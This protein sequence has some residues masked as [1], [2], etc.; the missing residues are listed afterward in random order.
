MTVPGT[1][2]VNHIILETNNVILEYDHST[3]GL[4]SPKES[5]FFKSPKLLVY[6]RPEALDIK[7]YASRYMH[8][9]RNRSLEIVLS[10]GWNQLESGELH[11]RAA[12]AGLRVQTSEA[13]VVKGSL[14]L[15]RKSEAGVVRFGTMD[16][17]SSASIVMPFNLE[18][19]VNDISLK[20]EISYTTDKGSFFFATT[21]SV[22]IMLPL[23]VNV[24]DV[25]KHKALFSKFTISSATSSPLRLLGS[26]LEGSEVF[27]A[28]SGL[29][30]SRPLVVFP[31]Q[32]ASMLYKITKSPSST[33]TRPASR[34]GP[35]S[36]LSLVLNYICLEEEIE[37]AVTLSLDQALANGPLAQY[38]R[39]IIP[40][41]LTQV[42]IRLSP[43]DLER[44]AVLSEFSTSILSSVKWRDQFAGLGRSVEQNQE[45]VILIE[46]CIKLWIQHAPNISL[47]PISLTDDTL[48][49]S[50]SIII[51]VDVP[52][53]SVVY[54]ADLKLLEPSSVPLD[55]VLAA[56]NQPLSAS[57]TIKYTRIW[58]TA[59][60][61]GPDTS[62]GDE[63]LEFFY[64]VSGATDTWLI[65][66]KRKGHFRIPRK[67]SSQDSNRKFTFPVVLIP[68]REGFLP[69]PNVD[70]KASPRIHNPGESSG[71]PDKKP[72]VVTCETDFKNAGETI[73]V[74]ADALKTTVSLDASGPQGGAWLLESERRGWGNGEVVLK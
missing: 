38:T 54:T 15:S 48:G 58:D 71:T 31:R 49:K 3:T 33:A 26:K 6:H 50:R 14:E 69:F 68:L 74:I 21:P 61:S 39:L 70:I 66:G 9:D 27:E 12:T 17:H 42:R 18:H 53:V 34:K 47:I 4:S 67:A 22:S 72:A 19:E 62:A 7:L 52:S 63:T 2:L 8:L 65:G 10:S 44:T 51:P 30:L 32:P 25:F 40:T 29:T 36:T 35:K 56:S 11:V 60:E 59:L 20:L 55:T 24:Q 16:P 73:R 45:V 41:V 13:K 1:Y 37:D 23:G 28:H 57:L 64:E 43:Y 5:R 46:K